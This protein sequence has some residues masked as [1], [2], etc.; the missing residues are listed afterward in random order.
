M[1]QPSAPGPDRA[2]QRDIAQALGISQVAVSLALRNSPRISAERRRQVHEQAARMGY[3]SNPHAT[4]LVRSKHRSAVPEIRTS[5]AWLN[6]WRDSR[7]LRNYPV[8]DGYWRGAQ[9]A[10]KK[11]GYHLEE[12][13]CNA[14]L[15]PA[16]LESILVARGVQGILLPPHSFQPDWGAFDW[17]RFS[18]VRL[19]R[20]PEMPSAHIVTADQVMNTILA[21]KAM[22]ARG[23]RRIGYVGF[24]DAANYRWLFEAGFLRTQLE[25]KTADRLPIFALHPITPR[26]SQAEFTRWLKRE[27]PDAILT[28]YPELPA[29]MKTSGWR[30]PVDV[31]LASV[32]NSGEAI[33]AGVD[34]NAEEI[35]RVAVLVLLSLLYDNDRG[36]PPIAREVLIK[37]IWV[38]G[39]SLPHRE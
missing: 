9:S 18:I 26:A 25:V 20:T 13:V 23:Y 1:N 12:F 11:F 28:P 8:F 31:G 19:G 33:D 37:G 14:R 17:S 30:V 22:R 5:L 36:I 3:S 39:A 6:C 10:A 7:Q 35:G 15:S 29:M 24:D 16:R 34:Q 32:T 38:D 2:V 4:G 27:K 21:I